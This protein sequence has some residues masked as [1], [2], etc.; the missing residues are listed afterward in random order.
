[1]KPAAHHIS[2]RKRKTMNASGA[3]YIQIAQMKF[4]S[5]L[6]VLVVV[7]VSYNIP[8]ATILL[9]YVINRNG[10]DN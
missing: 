5:F 10:S 1:M 7:A 3:H 2:A 6:C 8:L 9:L 4:I